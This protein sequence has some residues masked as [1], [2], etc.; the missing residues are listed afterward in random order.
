MLF[1]IDEFI[2][3][4]GAK[5]SW[6]KLNLSKKDVHLTP[7]GYRLVA[8]GIYHAIKNTLKIK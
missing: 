5:N 8:H 2:K 6:I 1:D 3:K 4:N 7:Q